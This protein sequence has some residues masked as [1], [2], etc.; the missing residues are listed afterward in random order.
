MSRSSKSIKKQKSVFE[1][2]TTENGE[3]NPKYVDLLYE[4]KPIS[5][6]KFVCLSFVSPEKIL[7]QKEIYYFEQFLKRWEF[8]KSV[9]V[10]VQFLSFIAF[11]FKL[12]F[13]ELYT[14]FHDFLSDKDVLDSFKMNKLKDAY[15]TFIEKNEEDLE[16]EFSKLNKFKTSIRGVKVRGSY[17][18]AEEAELR[19]KLLR[20]IDPDHDIFVGPVGFWLPWDPDANKTE[21]VYAEELLNQLMHEKKKNEEDAKIA[22]EK[23]TK[24]AKEKAIEDNVKNAKKTGNVL[25]QT[26]DTA[27]NLI[28]INNNTQQSNLL[29]NNNDINNMSSKDIQMELFEGENIITGKSD[30]GQSQLLTGPFAKK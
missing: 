18:T 2:K 20:E 4:D 30:N 5:T 24:E 28:G 12:S 25:T 8:N 7:K 26:I 11:K 6:Q 1:K 23:R 27:G 15:D 3:I 14:N 16:K 22:F 10:F 13:D 19:A 21:Q 9:E 17:P 29:K